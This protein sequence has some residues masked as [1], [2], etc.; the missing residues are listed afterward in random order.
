MKVSL[1]RGVCSVTLETDAY[2]EQPSGFQLQTLCNAAYAQLK[3][4]EEKQPS[5][6]AND[7]AEK[8]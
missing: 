6:G 4:L 1:T 5:T 2:K 7:G 3:Q 8:E